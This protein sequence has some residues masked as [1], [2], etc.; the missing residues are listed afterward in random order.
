MDACNENDVFGLL[1]KEKV[2]LRDQ[3]EISKTLDPRS[4]EY[5]NH[6]VRSRLTVF[7]TPPSSPPRDETLNESDHCK[8]TDHKAFVNTCENFAEEE[9]ALRA[10]STKDLRSMLIRDCMWNGYT[11]ATTEASNRSDSPCEKFRSLTKTPPLV[12][13]NLRIT[14]VDPSEIWPF[15]LAEQIKAGIRSSDDELKTSHVQ[16]NA[17][18][19]ASF[20]YYANCLLL[21]L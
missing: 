5:A 1:G 20:I 6:D 14:F 10:W 11:L 4:I 9:D 13:C 17:G 12:D 7:L 2:T 16:C 19:Q 8:L 3:G 18:T 15:N 21:T